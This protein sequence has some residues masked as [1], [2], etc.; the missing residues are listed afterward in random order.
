MPD[1]R[2]EK[3]LLLANSGYFNKKSLSVVCISSLESLVADKCLIK[4]NIYTFID[5]NS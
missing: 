1:F 4:I 3:K 5:I 2:D